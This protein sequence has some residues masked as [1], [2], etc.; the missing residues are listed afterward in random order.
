MRFTRLLILGAAVLAIGA[1]GAQGAGF[2][3]PTDE[4]IPPLAIKYLRVDATVENQVATTHVTQEFTN[5][6]SRDLECTYIF[7][8]PKGAAIRDFAMYIGGKR[9]KGELLAKE[10]ATQVYEEIVRRAKDPGLL[11][12]MDGSIL[13]LKIFPVVA[14]GT[15][16]V[17]IE[18]SEMVHMDE[19]LAEYAF[20]LKIGAKASKTLEDFTVSVRIKS[21]D[22]HQDR[23]QPHARGR[24][25]PPER[26][27]GRGRH[28]DEGGPA[29]P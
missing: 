20:P 15:Q 9:M 6:T 7:P 5:S 29:G 1:S 10:K 26:P 18:Y 4:S 28:G 2:L 22:A 17:E 25:L 13:R 19:G 24:H 16:K 27:R 23:L 14:H 8:L 11:E 21:A 3:V 12:Y